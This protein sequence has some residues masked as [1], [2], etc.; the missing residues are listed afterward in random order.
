MRSTTAALLLLLLPAASACSRP[1]DDVRHSVDA[2]A[3][4][5]TYKDTEALFRLHVDSEG[6]GVLCD[7]KFSALWDKAAA[8]RTPAHC[9]EAAEVAAMTP[10]QRQ[11]LDAAVVLL[12]EILDFQCR[13]PT[14]P[15][16]DFAEELF[17]RQ[18]KG[19]RLLTRDIKRVTVTRVDVVA[20]G[21]ATAYVDVAYEGNPTVDRIS[22]VLT[23]R[24]GRWLFKT[25]PW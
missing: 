23:E 22:L 12:S 5:A 7:A 9:T 24:Q 11:S 8:D 20:P 18:A 15:C 6:Q 10:N 19:S 2:F 16:R 14:A 17:H 4:A 13:S 25:Y 21:E 3:A 1:E